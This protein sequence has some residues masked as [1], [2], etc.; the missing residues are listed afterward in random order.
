MGE[1]KITSYELEEGKIAQ[2]S[3]SHNGKI[4]GIGKF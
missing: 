1:K 3:Q 4:G 2:V